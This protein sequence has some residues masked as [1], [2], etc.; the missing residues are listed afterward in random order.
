MITRHADRHSVAAI[1]TT[2]RPTA[3]A[4]GSVMR[5]AGRSRWTPRSSAL[6]PNLPAC[7]WE[8]EADAWLTARSEELRWLADA[9]PGV[10]AAPAGPA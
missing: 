1:A 10:A 9:R 2:A 8:W 5:P 4:A 3:A 7:R 6:A